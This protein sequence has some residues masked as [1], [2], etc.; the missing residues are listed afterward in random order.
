ME[1]TLGIMVEIIEILLQEFLR[2]NIIKNKIK[3][4]AKFNL[5]IKMTIKKKYALSVDI[6]ADIQEVQIAQVLSAKEKINND[7]YTIILYYII[8]ISHINIYYI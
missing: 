7:K 1:G 5:I 6:K 2:R 3:I 8:N 4:E